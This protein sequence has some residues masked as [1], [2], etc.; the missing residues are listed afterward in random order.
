MK[1][2][3]QNLK[4]LLAV[5]FSLALTGCGGGDYDG[6]DS[7]VSVSTPNK[8]LAFFNR[9]GDLSAGSYTLVIA[10]TTAGQTGSFSV[11]VKKN[12]GSSDQL[13]TGSWVNSFGPSASPLDTCTG[14][15]ANVCFSIDLHD[16]TGASFELSTALDGYLY[17]VDDSDT[18][19]I[20]GEANDNGAGGSEILEYSE[21]EI[22]ESSFAAAYYATVDP[23]NARDTLQKFQSLHG[24][25]TPGADVHVIFRDSKDLGYGTHLPESCRKA[26]AA[27]PLRCIS[28][29]HPEK[30]A[31][32]GNP[33]DFAKQVQPRDSTRIMANCGMRAG[34][35]GKR[36]PN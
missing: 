36:E 26:A 22:D 24:F 1:Y 4:L 20:V 30:G 15:P 10:T 18:P 14:L 27:S 11:L 33:Q 2:P 9:Q 35:P 21:S 17:L 19:E 12:D 28:A 25:D 23:A 5:L 29:T 34:Q 7:S 13:L 16:A 6:F 32:R 3:G 31:G 8:F